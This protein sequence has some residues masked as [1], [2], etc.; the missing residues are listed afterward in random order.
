M[1]AVGAL[2]LKSESRVYTHSAGLRQTA[3]YDGS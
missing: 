3:A 2:F 1:I